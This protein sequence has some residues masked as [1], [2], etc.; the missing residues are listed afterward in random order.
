MIYQVPGSW[1]RDE[2]AESVHPASLFEITDTFSSFFCVITLYNHGVVWLLRVAARIS[3]LLAAK[4]DE[5]RKTPQAMMGY[6]RILSRHTL[7]QLLE[8]IR[9]HT[10]LCN[11]W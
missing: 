6:G 11:C 10:P 9:P 4:T 5:W 3:G 2:D 8:F 1:V 7:S